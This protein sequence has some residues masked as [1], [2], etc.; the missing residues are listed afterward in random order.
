MGQIER[1]EAKI[2]RRISIKEAMDAKVWSFRFCFLFISSGDPRQR[3]FF[4]FLLAFFFFL[5]FPHD[6]FV[7]PKIGLYQL[8]FFKADFQ[9]VE[10][11][12]QT[13]T[14][15]VDR[16]NIALNLNRK[17]YLSNLL[18]WKLQPI[19]KIPVTGS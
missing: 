5:T 12:E 8:K 17:V 14:S 16:R 19:R 15:V 7:Y 13:G 3:V 6:N 9:S 10:F 2:Q 11:S 4:L 18:L 1:G